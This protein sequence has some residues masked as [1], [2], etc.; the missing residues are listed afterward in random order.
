MNSIK[1]CGSIEINT[2]RLHLRPFNTEDAKVAFEGWTSDPRVA[3]FTT[4]Y[5]HSN[6][7]ETKGYINYILSLDAATSYNWIIEKD[8]K[9]I[10]TINVC[11]S[12]DHLGV[13]G[14]A[15]AFSYN[16]WGKGYAT[17]AAR[18]VSR[19]LFDIGYRK[20]IAGCDADNTGSVRVLEKIGMKQ[21]G[22]FRKYI[23]RKDG[24]WGD[25]L[26]FG[27]F[28]DELRID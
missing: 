2:E 15:Y 27:M 5:A 7:E 17:E 24:S 25:D 21:E 28:E 3:E 14:L 23:L 9:A 13:A 20:I 22:R 10:G 8:D 6:I 4:W 11:Y 18:K 16:S 26:Q 1:H 19:F 12:D